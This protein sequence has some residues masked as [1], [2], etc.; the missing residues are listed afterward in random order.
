MSHLTWVLETDI[1]TSR[2]A[3]HMFLITEPSLQSPRTSYSQI[4][5][6]RRAY[7]G[8]AFT[9]VAVTLI[10]SLLLRYLMLLK[11]TLCHKYLL[12]TR[13]PN[14]GDKFKW[15]RMN[16]FLPARVHVR[17]TSGIVPNQ[18]PAAI[19]G[20]GVLIVAN[21]IAFLERDKAHKIKTL[22]ILIWET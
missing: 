17:L 11:P 5:Y 16:T 12:V 15:R 8:V 19:I 7:Q 3:A 4:L 9:I 6:F 18:L 1:R 2:K 14:P 21:T 13:C 10:L 20:T 22:P